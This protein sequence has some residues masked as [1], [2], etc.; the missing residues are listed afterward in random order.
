[1]KTTYPHL[2]WPLPTTSG[3]NL[4]KPL[5]NVYC[6]HSSSFSV[7]KAFHFL[8]NENE[9]RIRNC[10]SSPRPSLTRCR[11]VMFLSALES[12]PRASR[13]SRRSYTSYW[14]HEWEK[15]NISRSRVV[16]GATAPN[17]D[18]PLVLEARADKSLQSSLAAAPRWE[19]ERVP[20]NWSS[21]SELFTVTPRK[22]LLSSIPCF[23]RRR[24]CLIHAG[25]LSNSRTPW[26]WPN[27]PD[28]SCKINYLPID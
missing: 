21:Y 14:G 17:D 3:C 24:S 4:L 18:F 22:V 11:N 6:Q 9:T 7:L 2:P 10:I 19:S 28:C 8:Q 12:T 16:L 1:M 26:S 15:A 5:G 13:M 25:H 27:Q 20:Q 23:L